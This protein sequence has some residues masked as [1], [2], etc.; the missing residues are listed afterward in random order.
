MM[1]IAVRCRQGRRGHEEASALA[2]PRAVRYRN[3]AN[4]LLR[5]PAFPQD[6]G[7]ALAD[8]VARRTS[9]GGHFPSLEN[10]PSR[11]PA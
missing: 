9:E 10:L 1:D 3:L 7:E 2:A 5:Q 4:P 11:R 6:R 8:F